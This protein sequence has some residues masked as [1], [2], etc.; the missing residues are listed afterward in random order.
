MIAFLAATFAAAAPATVLDHRVEIDIASDQTLSVNQTWTVRIDDPAE[1]AAGLLTP[2]GLDG[3]ADGDAIV[4]EGL[5]VL[6]PTVQPGDVLTLRRTTSSTLGSWSFAS[7]PDLPIHSAT[8]RVRSASPLTTWADDRATTTPESTSWLAEWRDVPADR[9]ATAVVTA[10]SSWADVGESLNRAVEARLGSRESLGR[11]LAAGISATSP[12]ELADRLA[13][14]VQLDNASE[15]WWEAAPSAET[16]NAGRGSAADRGIVLLNLLRLSGVDAVPGLMAPASNPA[17]APA[18]AAPAQMPRPV[19]AI[20][21][22]SGALD[23]LDPAADRVLLGSLPPTMIGSTVW[24]VDDLPDRVGGRGVPSGAISISTD[25]VIG[26]DGTATWRTDATATGAAVSGLRTLLAP[27]TDVQRREALARRIGWGR[28]GESFQ[29][30]VTG[31][32]RLGGELRITATGKSAGAFASVGKGRVGTIAPALAPGLGAWV[33]PDT[34]VRET[35]SISPPPGLRVAA[36]MRPESFA[37]ADV[38]VS[39]AATV[40]AGR[41]VATHEVLRPYQ[42]TTPSREAAATAALEQAAKLGT[43]ALLVPTPKAAVARSFRIAPGRPIPDLVLFEAL[44][45]ADAGQPNRATDAMAAQA[46]VDLAGL[47]ERLSRMDAGA[48][49]TLGSALARLDLGPEQLDLVSH[50]LM[51]VGRTREAWL[52]AYRG[53]TAATGATRARLVLRMEATQGERPDPVTDP[54]G[55]AAWREPELLRKWAQEAAPDAPEV[56]VRLATLAIASRQYADAESI[57]ARVDSG[58]PDAAL[59]RARLASAAGLDPDLVGRQLRAALNAAPDDA[60]LAAKAAEF[61]AQGNDLALAADLAKSAARLD[62]TNSARWTFASQAALRAGRLAA[63]VACAR[64]ASDAD[65]QDAGLATRLATL[66]TLAMDEASAELGRRRAGRYDGPA[67]TSDLATL[68]SRTPAE[69]RWAVLEHHNG[70]VSAS[71][72]ALIERARFRL[73]QGELDGAAHDGSAAWIQ[74]QRPDGALLAYVASAGRSSPTLLSAWLKASSPAQESGRVALESALLTGLP[75]TVTLAKDSHDAGANAVAK[76]LGSKQV[77]AEWPRDLKEPAP[78]VP[79]GFRSH[80]LGQALPGTSAAVDPDRMILLIRVGGI[81]GVVP[82][83]FGAL[84]TL[85]EAPM[86]VTEEG[87]QATV[88]RGHVLPIVA[89]V[90]I[91]GGEELWAIGPHLPALLSTLQ[92]VVVTSPP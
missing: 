38:Q 36:T 85:D 75:Q 24:V 5:L 45:W 40:T 83:P 79:P 69:A 76:L 65:P 87:I 46:N 41:L 66:A 56:Q 60:E 23:W 70:P 12:A 16:V 59:L 90:R 31:V 81:A 47:V 3:A 88:L 64:R 27:L 17:P 53:H 58:R 30:T 37:T 57:L 14:S 91:V 68:L 11:D 1:C 55:N 2:L 54:E 22:R 50:G 21:Y 48:Q 8:V 67:M 71:P 9:S 44:T 72:E 84:R 73:E 49:G 80:P 10:W 92:D 19:V 34:L 89:A 7:A 62:T 74:F 15:S 39:H 33:P 20:R 86:R 32:D 77:P 43:E 52:A 13:K 35:V 42:S 63:A 78:L 28:Q 29:I 82:P 26:D 4:L 25:V 61:A 6:P 18:L 51:S